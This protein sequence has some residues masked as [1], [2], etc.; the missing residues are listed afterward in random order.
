MPQQ[1]VDCRRVEE[2]RI[3][4]DWT[5]N[6]IRPDVRNHDQIALGSAIS[7]FLSLQ[8]PSGIRTR[9]FGLERKNDLEQR[10]SGWIELRLNYFYDFLERNS[11]VRNRVHHNFTHS[12]HQFLKARISR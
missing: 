7:D 12:R 9:H 1:S 8:I 6:L 5:K 11:V 3:V 10:V 2:F 4:R